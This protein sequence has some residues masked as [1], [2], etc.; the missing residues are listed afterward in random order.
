MPK[1]ATPLSETQIRAMEPR[2]TRYSVADGNGLVLE[3]MP[4]GTKVWRFR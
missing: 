4:T 2:A 3:V 1:A